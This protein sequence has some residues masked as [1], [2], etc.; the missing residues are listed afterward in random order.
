MALHAT[1]HAESWVECYGR[2]GSELRNRE[3]PS[4][5]TLLPKLLEKVPIMLYAGDQDFICNYVG[6]E[7]LIGAMTWNGMQGLGV[8]F[9]ETLERRKFDRLCRLWRRSLGQWTERL[10]VHGWSRGT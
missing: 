8:S 5:I 4:S 1:G 6:M 10:L 7:S 9:S 2:I 3:S